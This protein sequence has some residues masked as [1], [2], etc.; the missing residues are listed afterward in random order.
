MPHEL[1]FV[2]ARPQV[3]FRGDR[4]AVWSETAAKFF[5]VNVS[6][7]CRTLAATG[8]DVNA[9]AFATRLDLLPVMDQH[10]DEHGVVSIRVSRMAEECIGQP[11]A[12]PLAGPGTDIVIAVKNVSDEPAIF[13]AAI[14]GDIEYGN[15]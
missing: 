14:L 8:G 9:D 2:T 11:L 3:P 7:A 15:Y 13:V 1:E 4:L 5:I 10:L 12:F 6:V